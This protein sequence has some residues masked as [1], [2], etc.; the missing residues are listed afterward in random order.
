LLPETQEEFLAEA[1]EARRAEYTSKILFLLCISCIWFGCNNAAKEIVKERTIYHKERDVGLAKIS[2]YGSKLIL[3]G[4][5]S[6]LQV[7]V[8]YGIVRF[9]TSLGGEEVEQLLLLSLSSLTGVSLG[10]AI[11]TLANSE[12]L[13]VTIVPIIL[14]P[15]IIMAGL[16][17]PLVGYARVFAQ[18]FISAY[19]AYQGLL[20]QA[21]PTLQDRLRDANT[22]DLGSEWT[23]AKVASVLVVHILVFA[24]L[25]LAVLYARDR[26]ETRVRLVLWPGRR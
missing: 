4:F 14:I 6:V 3:L 20:K 19:W 12:D 13:A 9:F 22:L 23:L 24:V 17:A 1:A 8:L 15:Q 7:G 18:V 16:I 26:K 2:Y 11:S 5:L 10:L 21:E 25:A